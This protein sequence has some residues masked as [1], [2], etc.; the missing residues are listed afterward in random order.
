MFKKMI[1]AAF[2]M[3]AGCQAE[4]AIKDLE[5]LKTK[6]CECK[7]AAC[8]DKVQN[9]LEVWMKRNNKTSGTKDQEDRVI[10]LGEEICDCLRD[11]RKN[12]AP[13]DKK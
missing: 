2:L 13:A 4:E 6:A 3:T 7:D 8:A 9:R 1:V 10:T 5:G 11:A 12:E